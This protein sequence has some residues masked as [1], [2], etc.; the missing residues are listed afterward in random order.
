VFFGKR[1]IDLDTEAGIVVHMDVAMPDFSALLEQ[2][3]PD[4]IAGFVA[5]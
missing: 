3:M 2:A 5:V 1:P 4:R